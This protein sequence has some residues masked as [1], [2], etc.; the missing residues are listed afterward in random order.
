MPFFSLDC[1]RMVFPCLHHKLTATPLG[2]S[3]EGRCRYLWIRFLWNLQTKYTHSWQSDA[4]N[5]SCFLM[6][7]HDK[8]PKVLNWLSI[9]SR[10]I[11]SFLYFFLN[12][13]QCVFS[14]RWQTWKIKRE[15]ENRLQCRIMQPILQLLGRR[16]CHVD[17]RGR[18]SHVF[19]SG[20]AVDKV[21]LQRRRALLF[22]CPGN[23]VVFCSCQVLRHAVFFALYARGDTWR[24]VSTVS[25]WSE[26]SLS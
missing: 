21:L 20:V 19:S 7:E 6:E 26:V 10:L 4:D 17:H 8:K 2:C 25:K 24:S 11:F 1:G 5:V 3:V 12:G 9:R 22:F 14:P 23:G 15:N 16:L 18:E 13:G